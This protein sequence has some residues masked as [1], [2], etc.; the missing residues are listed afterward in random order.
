M[1]GKGKFIW[2]AAALL[3]CATAGLGMAI[4]GAQE[5]QLGKTETLEPL[6]DEALLQLEE[7]GTFLPIG[8][9]GGASREML[10][11][12]VIS[13]AGYD[14]TKL[15]GPEHITA[16]T[17]YENAALVLKTLFGLDMPEGMEAVFQKD[18]S[19]QRSDIW[20]LS[21]YGDDRAENHCNILVSA[22]SGKVYWVDTPKF[23]DPDWNE[24]GTERSYTEADEARYIAAAREIAETWLLTDGREAEYQVN[25]V[26]GDGYWADCWA[27]DIKTAGECYRLE[28]VGGASKPISL[29][30]MNV[31][32]DWE[33]CWGGFAYVA[34][35]LL[36]EQEREAW[37]NAD[38]IE[39]VAS[40]PTEIPEGVAAQLVDSALS[41]VGKPFSLEGYGPDS[42]GPAGLVCQCLTEVGIDT[43]AS[44]VAKLAAV[45]K[46][47]YTLLN[48][49]DEVQTG[50]ILFFN[51]SDGELSH[52]GICVGEGEMVDASSSAGKVR[53]GSYATSYWRQ[54]FAFAVRIP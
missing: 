40:M 21:N 11:G 20:Q 36:E 23:F 28:L 43:A 30:R 44:D 22:L 15:P 14:D 49:M 26:H 32:P 45:L 10:Q 47:R 12:Q 25:A 51:N 53:M 31:F 2:I 27:V 41:Y 24:L 46:G 48:S 4:A 13:Y 35:L 9:P 17:A 50:D 52:C 1:Y 29:Y 16:E 19:G 33:C 37:Q 38:G 39:A 3:L 5:M 6:E 34:D 18:Q 42:F 7:I 54:N 8:A